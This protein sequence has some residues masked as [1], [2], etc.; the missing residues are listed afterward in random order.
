MVPTMLEMCFEAGS[1]PIQRQHQWPLFSVII[2]YLHGATKRGPNECE[3]ISA[4][5]NAISR[6]W[7]SDGSVESPKWR[8]NCLALKT[9]FLKLE[10]W[11]RLAIFIFQKST[12]SFQL[13]LRSLSFHYPG[14]CVCNTRMWAL[15]SHNRQ[16]LWPTC[17]WGS[18]WTIVAASVQQWLDES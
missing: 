7:I 17:V 3:G 13:L 5:T 2:A 16:C 9:F 12:A 18:L 11:Q 1:K 6:M 15:V 4:Q 14:R 10:M 8:H